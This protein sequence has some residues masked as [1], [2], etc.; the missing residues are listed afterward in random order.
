MRSE[1][2]VETIG[3]VRIVEQI[4]ADEMFLKQFR[5]AGSDVKGSNLS[6]QGSR[7]WR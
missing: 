7:F 2:W 4:E 5:L 6:E 1:P 3:G